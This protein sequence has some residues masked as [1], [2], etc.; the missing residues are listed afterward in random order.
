MRAARA[1]CRGKNVTVT[2]GLT[3]GVR[4]THAAA[5]G[6]EANET[7]FAFLVSCLQRRRRSKAAPSK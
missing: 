7:T 4:S 2:S 6:A 3:L 1:T 5:S